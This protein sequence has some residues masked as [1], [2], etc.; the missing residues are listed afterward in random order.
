MSVASP[1]RVDVLEHDEVVGTSGTTKV[2]L[3]AGRHDV[4]LRNDSVGYEARHSVDVVAGGVATIQ[5][6]PPKASLN[7]NARPWA[8]VT[9]DGAAV[10]QTPLANVMITVGTLSNSSS[11]RSRSLANRLVR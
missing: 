11:T 7:V 4:V 1:F 6:V 8:D 10:G 5:V 2:M 9:I 3:P